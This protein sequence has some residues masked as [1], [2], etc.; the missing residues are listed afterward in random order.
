MPSSGTCAVGP[1]TLFT[2]LTRR[3][4]FRVTAVYVVVAWVVIQAAD[5]IFPNLGLPT[6][7]TTLVIVLVFGL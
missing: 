3:R 4:V 7:A 1:S 5:T 2:E 6:S